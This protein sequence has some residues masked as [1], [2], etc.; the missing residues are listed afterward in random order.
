MNRVQE[1]LC[2]DCVA[3]CNMTEEDMATCVEM[4]LDEMCELVASISIANHAS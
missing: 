2:R 4:L 1:I 3:E